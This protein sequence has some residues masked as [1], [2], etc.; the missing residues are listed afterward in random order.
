MSVVYSIT[1]LPKIYKIPEL[2]NV[3]MWD[4]LLLNSTDIFYLYAIKCQKLYY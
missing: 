4:H 2:Y 3:Y 1:Q